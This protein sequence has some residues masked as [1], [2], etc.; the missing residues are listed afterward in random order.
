MAHLSHV[1]LGLNPSLPSSPSFLVR[2]YYQLQFFHLQNGTN[3]SVVK[4]I[5]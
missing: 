3:Y 4:R 2:N 1:A 5:Q